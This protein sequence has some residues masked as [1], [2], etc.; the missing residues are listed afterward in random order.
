M[1]PT[2]DKARKAYK[3][4]QRDYRRGA[5]DN[6]YQWFSRQQGMMLSAWW[7]AGQQHAREQEEKQ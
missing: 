2:T 4:G 3:R 7:E 5:H 6:P 1:Q